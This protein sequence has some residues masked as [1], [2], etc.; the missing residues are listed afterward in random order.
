MNHIVD[1]PFAELVEGGEPASQLAKNE[2][3]NVEPIPS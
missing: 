1:D 2:T 3:K